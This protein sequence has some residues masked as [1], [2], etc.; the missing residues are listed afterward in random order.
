VAT[1][2]SVGW[3][4]GKRGIERPGNVAGT[5]EAPGSLQK[6]EASTWPLGTRFVMLQK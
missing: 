5:S 3:T 2:R 4:A 1:E 6:G